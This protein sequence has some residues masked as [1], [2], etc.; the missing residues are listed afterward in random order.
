RAD[1]LPRLAC[2]SEAARAR[3]SGP[4][5]TRRWRSASLSAVEFVTPSSVEGVTAPGVAVWPHGHPAPAPRRGDGRGDRLDAAGPAG[6][7]G[8]RAALAAPVRDPR[9]A[10]DQRPWPGGAHV[11]DRPARGADRQPR[12]APG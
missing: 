8:R 12:A 4:S 11:G 5:A 6:R 7:G 2:F 1:F 3:A 9:P 10:A